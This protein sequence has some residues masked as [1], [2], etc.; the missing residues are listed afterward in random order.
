MP[1]NVLPCPSCDRSNVCPPSPPI[2]YEC[3]VGGLQ[4]SLSATNKTGMDVQGE[5]CQGRMP[6]PVLLIT[7]C[8]VLFCDVPHLSPH[9]DK[10]YSFCIHG[11]QRRRNYLYAKK[12][13]AV[14]LMNTGYPVEEHW[15]RNVQLHQGLPG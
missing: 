3:A 9:I 12:L 11:L 7:L 4:H 2:K 13:C 10:V 6:A 15:T 1:C 8:N 5:G 14:S